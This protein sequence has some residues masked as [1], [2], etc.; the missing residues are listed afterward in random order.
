M[1]FIKS[2]LTRTSNSARA[3]SIYAAVPS[4]TEVSSKL[5]K[6]NKT[7]KAAVPA[8]YFV[9]KPMYECC[10]ECLNTVN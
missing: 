7:S 4:S 10:V 9:L 6:E 5:R 2:V 3:F 1:T 8:F